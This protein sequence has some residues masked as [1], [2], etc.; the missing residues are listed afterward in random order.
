MTENREYWEKIA[1]ECGVTLEFLDAIVTKAAIE[2]GWRAGL[3]LGSK[4]G[5]DGDGI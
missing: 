5:L 3:E 1:A 2:L 4:E